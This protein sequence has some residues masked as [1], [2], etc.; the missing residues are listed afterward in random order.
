MRK[1]VPINEK[2]D[3]ES[4]SVGT[5]ARGLDVLE[6]FTQAEPEFSQT[7]ISDRLG[8]PVPTV[9][10]LAKLL[11]ER[12]YLERDPH[13]RR[14]RLGLAV[15]RLQPALLSGLRLSDVARDH[16]RRL[17]EQTGETASLA[18]LHGSEVVYLLSE[19]GSKRLTPRAAIG[20]RL[21]VHC[22]ALGKCLLAQLPEPEARAAA[23]PEPYAALTERTL[24]G[25]PELRRNLARIRSAGV[26]HSHG[27]YEPGLDSLAV[28][29]RWPGS[30]GP[31][32]INVALPSARAV[33]EQRAVLADR[34]RAT[35]DAIE[36]VA[37]IHQGHASTG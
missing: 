6:L 34:L 24:T 22:T 10:R 33:R 18:M 1:A 37:G 11:I 25:W 32:A 26:S 27:E 3:G 36:T 35:R 5:L 28:P 14:L 13:S 8:L 9:H 19:S 15:A 16:L 23:G 4:T 17:A 21:P 29:V 12:G 20:L 7:Q 2:E 31:V 30:D